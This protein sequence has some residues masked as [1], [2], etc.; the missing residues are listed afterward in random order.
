MSVDYVVNSQEKTPTPSKISQMRADGFK[1]GSR[2]EIILKKGAEYYNGYTPAPT[3]NPEGFDPAE[4]MVNEPGARYSGY[5][6][7][8][9][10]DQR[11]NSVTLAFGWDENADRWKPQT[12]TL[13]FEEETI[14]SYNK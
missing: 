5:I 1:E 7:Q 9:R 14:F 6:A 11:V 4:E 12:K 13:Y 2:I 3:V 8:F 10:Q